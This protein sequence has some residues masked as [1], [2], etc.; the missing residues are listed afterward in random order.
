[1]KKT[2][3]W[4]ELAALLFLAALFG[5]LLVL[6]ADLFVLPFIQGKL[7]PK[8]QMPSI[9]GL[10]SAA[11]AALL[12]KEGFKTGEIER[13]NND[14]VAAGRVVRQVPLP[15]EE[16]K[17]KR[18]IRYTLSL[19]REMVTV[20]DLTELS[21]AQAGDTLQRL[22][23]RL[24]EVNEEYRGDRTPGAI[25]ASRPGAG[26]RVPRGGTIHLTISQNRLTGETYIPDFL[27]LSLDE[28]RQ[29]IVKAGLRLRQVDVRR[30]PEVLPRTV[31]EQSIKAGTR[32]EKETFID[33][34]VA[35]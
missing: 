33:L 21:P 29:N 22:G 34:V 12:L 23:L 11:A 10:D 28:A 24:G 26:R 8:V 2:T 6:S 30:A 25:I 16:V 5:L 1:M 18:H 15:G 20:P 35:E 7:S 32:V 17:K 19:G 9:V 3:S 14:S 4:A 27:N 13:A 31:L